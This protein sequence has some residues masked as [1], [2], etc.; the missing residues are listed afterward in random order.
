MQNSAKSIIFIGPFQTTKLR[1]GQPLKC[2][3]FQCGS[4]RIEPQSVGAVPANQPSGTLNQKN[5]PPVK[6]APR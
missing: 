2:Y 1:P 6:A 5:D 4:F 3:K